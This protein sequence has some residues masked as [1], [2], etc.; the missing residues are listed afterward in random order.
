MQIIWSY[1]E[2][3]FEGIFIKGTEPKQISENIPIIKQYKILCKLND[4]SL[5]YELENADGIYILNSK[6]KVIGKANCSPYYFKLPYGKHKL[7]IQPYKII[8]GKTIFG[9]SIL[10]PELILQKQVPREWWRD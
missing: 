2:N 4:I 9:K 10:I 5:F 1:D 8:N 7:I 6:N 3:S